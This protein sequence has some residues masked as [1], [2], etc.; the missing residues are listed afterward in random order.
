MWVKR[1]VDFIVE[2]YKTTNTHLNLDMLFDPMKNNNDSLMLPKQP[3][4][5]KSDAV[6]RNDVMK[7][8]ESSKQRDAE[9][10]T[11]RRQVDFKSA[12]LKFSKAGHNLNMISPN[13]EE[14]LKKG[15]KD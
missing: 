11:L 3:H 12:S 5:F 15:T 4:H 14:K 9:S 13:D 7:K 2:L 1:D 10:M 8:T 6:S